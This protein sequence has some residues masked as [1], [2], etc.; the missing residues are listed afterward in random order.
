MKDRFV[1][2]FSI[3]FISVLL[4]PHRCISQNLKKISKKIPV[5][6]IKQIEAFSL[7]NNLYVFHTSS[8]R[9][10]WDHRQ[11]KIIYQSD[12][13]F[14]PSSDSTVIS[15]VGPETIGFLDLTT[16]QV[17][18]VNPRA[19]PDT[20]L[21]KK[22]MENGAVDQCVFYAKEKT[23]L[24]GIG[25]IYE[26]EIE[27][28]PG[29][30]S[31]E[32]FG[33]EWGM[34]YY[35]DFGDYLRL[36][37]LLDEYVLGDRHLYSIQTGKLIREDLSGFSIINDHFI[38][39]E[40]PMDSA[41]VY[42]KEFN[43]VFENIGPGQ[44]E[45]NHFQRLIDPSISKAE[46]IMGGI[47]LCHYT[48]GQLRFYD[49]W[50]MKPLSGFYDWVSSP[51]YNFLEKGY[52]FFTG[53]DSGFG[54][55]NTW[56]QETIKPK[57]KN[58]EL[59]AFYDGSFGYRAGNKLHPIRKNFTGLYTYA[60]DEINGPYELTSWNDS[61][62][63]ESLIITHLGIQGEHLVISIRATTGDTH[64][65]SHYTRTD[66]LD[67]S[68]VFS[69]ADSTWLI[70]PKYHSITPYKEHYLAMEITSVYPNSSSLQTTI[71]NTDFEPITD[72]GFG[73]TFIYKGMLIFRDG[74]E[75]IQYDLENNSLTRLGEMNEIN[76]DFKLIDGYLVIGDNNY[77][78]GKLIK[79]SDCIHDDCYEK[80]FKGMD[81]SD[82]VTPAGKLV[83]VPVDR[84]R[85]KE[86]VGDD[87]MIIGRIKKNSPDD[88]HLHLQKIDAYAVFDLRSGNLISPWYTSIEKAGGNLKFN[89]TVPLKE[90]RRHF[91]GQ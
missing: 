29:D 39:S 89:Q 3:A 67:G 68:G 73:Y 71:L 72:R 60:G 62:E 52:E 40:N 49:S 36:E 30:N 33:G 54:L 7:A 80:I 61:L 85:F 66:F 58:I 56:D 27:V 18:S 63:R 88:T 44:F 77:R 86:Y 48:S 15:I 28:Y 20:V 10:L 75:Y 42:D 84:F 31:E 65:Q 6:N 21:I 11:E 74:D 53:K 2:L 82:V 87:L 45:A 81:I 50:L 57:Y 76:A 83:N 16:Y 32:D 46:Y 69:L 78:R 12:V 35:Y 41:T 4:H 37:W 24:F 26:G 22:E 38:F 47:Y 17:C 1:I 23:L 59:R 14:L 64:D 25:E 91:S 19:S 43:L 55:F 34:E 79:E 51:R 5:E 8:E 13:W 70:E 90:V 9:G